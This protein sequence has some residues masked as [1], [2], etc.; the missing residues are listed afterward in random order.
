MS[1]DLNKLVK[2]SALQQLVEKIKNIFATK[3][4]VSQIPFILTF[5][6]EDSWA[7]ESNGTVDKSNE[8]IINAIKLKKEIICRYKFSNK[9]KIQTLP[10]ISITASFDNVYYGITSYYWTV[11]DPQTL[12]ELGEWRC[13]TWHYDSSTDIT[14]I[15]IEYKG[16]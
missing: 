15:R 9:N 2:L 14:E 16:D 7:S 8:E 11:S 6:S 10:D 4:E 3:E 5:S 1:Y 12:S 13:C